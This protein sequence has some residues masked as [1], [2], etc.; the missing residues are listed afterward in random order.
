MFENYTGRGGEKGACKDFADLARYM[1][2]AQIEHVDETRNGG[3]RGQ[4]F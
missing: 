3:R 2:T 4:G 1:A